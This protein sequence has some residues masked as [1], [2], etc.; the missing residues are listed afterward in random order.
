MLWPKTKKEHPVG[1]MA[2]TTAASNRGRRAGTKVRC[3]PW[4]ATEEAQLRALVDAGTKAQQQKK[5]MWVEIAAQLDNRTVASVEQHFYYMERQ[6]R[7]KSGTPVT[8]GGSAPKTKSK[9]SACAAAQPSASKIAKVEA[10]KGRQIKVEDA[11]A[12]V[13]REAEAQSIDTPGALDRVLQLFHG[14]RELILGFNAFLPPG[15]KIEFSDDEKAPRVQLKYPHGVTG[16]Q[17]QY[18]PLAQPPAAP[19]EEYVDED[20]AEIMRR[21]EKCDEEG[22]CFEC[23]RKHRGNSLP[24][25]IRHPADEMQEIQDVEFCY[26]CYDRVR[27][28][29]RR[30]LGMSHFSDDDGCD[31]DSDDSDRSDASWDY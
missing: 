5:A 28:A 3:K 13:D 21:L 10:T 29:R 11:L 25:W 8:G 22:R 23:M 2:T 14:H 6:E 18:N 19:A 7:A 24:Y 16:P 27:N 20:V 17:P 30:E 31:S 15:Y 12:Y 4:T 26:D 1:G 9:V